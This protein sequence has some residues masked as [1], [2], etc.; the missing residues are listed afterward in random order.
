M[1]NQNECV[2]STLQVNNNYFPTGTGTSG[3]VE[4]YDTQNSNAQTNLTA[5][6][7][8]YT[9]VCSGW[10][11]ANG[12]AADGGTELNLWDAVLG[13]T[14]ITVN[15]AGTVL[16]LT[17]PTTAAFQPPMQIA[18]PSIIQI[19][20]DFNLTTGTLTLASYTSGTSPPANQP[21]INPYYAADVWSA[22]CPQ[23]YYQPLNVSY[24]SSTGLLSATQYQ[25]G[26]PADWSA[27]APIPNGTISLN[28]DTCALGSAV[29]FNV[30]IAGPAASFSCV[31]P[32]PATTTSV[33]LDY[34]QCV[35]D[36]NAT[37]GVVA[38]EIKSSPGLAC[39]CIP[40]Y[41]GGGGHR[42]RAQY[43]VLFHRRHDYGERL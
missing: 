31:T 10:S 34:N 11:A 9:N 32:A 13:G 15:A 5:T 16:Q 36:P 17:N 43:R 2:P 19:A 14:D 4:C 23:S 26:C 41:I 21:T 35:N 24:D 42:E 1:Y 29:N 30:V 6:A 18:D 20:T 22:Y 25:G 33:A 38:M 37:G 27:A 12:C 8:T 28:M 3:V 39:V 40:Y 7:G